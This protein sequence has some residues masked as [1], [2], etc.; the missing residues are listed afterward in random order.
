MNAL[1]F[2][3]EEVM[4]QLITL[5]GSPLQDA[6][7]CGGTALSRCW[8][9]HR[10]SYDLDF[11]L[12]EG[13]DPVRLSATFK[14]AKVH[15]QDV[16][17]TTDSRIAN[18][19]H[20]TIIHEGQRLKVSFIEDAYYGLYPIE[21]REFG[22]LKVNTECVDGL[23]HRKLRTVSGRLSEGDQVIGGRQTARDLFDLYVLSNAHASLM[24][25]MESL[26][27]SFPKEAF[28]TGLVAMP[29]FELQQELSEIVCSPQWVQ[30]KDMDELKANLMA[31]IGAVECGDEWNTGDSDENAP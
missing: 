3:Q 21:V 13:F 27:Y 5:P 19:L 31:Q 1:Y 28:I 29:W 23:Y 26:P 17:M 12:P 8:L 15:L 16:S 7:L 18:Q 9:N 4:A 30:G 10:I 6:K 14:Q 25:Q 24:K 11:F 2:L 20:G 22:P